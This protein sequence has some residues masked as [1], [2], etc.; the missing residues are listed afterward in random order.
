MHK[1]DE[2][3]FMVAAEGMIGK[4]YKRGADGPYE[5]DCYGV[6]QQLVPFTGVTLPRINRADV[7]SMVGFTK[8]LMGH[9]DKKQWIEVFGMPQSGDIMVMANVDSRDH[10]M[11]MYAIVSNTAVCV[12]AD[13]V[14]G[15]LC[16]DVL[17]LGYR[18]LNKLTYL[19]HVE[20][21]S[22]QQETSS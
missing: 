2:Q 16:E 17:T 14:L 18:G 21:I 11:G 13:T 10:H 15:V 1:F 4:P 20:N 8:L 7:D 19:R 12:H 22:F 6:I 9:A 3:G 5:Y